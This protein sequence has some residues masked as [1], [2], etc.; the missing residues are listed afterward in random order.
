MPERSEDPT[1]ETREERPSGRDPEWVA[2]VAALQTAAN[3][4]GAIDVE[5]LQDLDEEELAGLE[6]ELRASA[7]FFEE[8]FAARGEGKPTVPPTSSLSTFSPVRLKKVP[9]TLAAGLSSDLSG[10][11]RDVEQLSSFHALG[12]Y[13]KAVDS[14]RFLSWARRKLTGLPDQAGPRPA[15]GAMPVF[16]PPARPAPA[17]AKP[18]PPG[19]PALQRPP[20]AEPRPAQ[21]RTSSSASMLAA[22]A[23]PPEAR[24]TPPPAAVP[25]Q[26]TAREPARA[27]IDLSVYEIRPDEAGGRVTAGPVTVWYASY[28]ATPSALRPANQAATLAQPVKGGVAFALAEGLSSSLGARTAAA[29][30]VRSFC[31]LAMAAVAAG[32]D[33]AR[34]VRDG[35]GGTHQRLDLLSHALVASGAGSAALTLIRGS[36]PADNALKILAHTLA[37]DGRLKHVGPALT[38][39]FTGGVL[40]PNP[41]TGAPE[42]WL[43]RVGGGRA[44]WRRM[45]AGQPLI[46]PGPT[47][48][49]PAVLGPGPTG[50]AGLAALEVKG[51]YEV[52]LGDIVV[53][54]GEE[55]MR[56]GER[57]AW[58]RLQE[59][60]PRFET[61]GG[62]DDRARRLLERVAR[63]TH[64][65]LGA[66]KVAD[67]DLA[68]VLLSFDATPAA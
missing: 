14:V 52:R 56:G 54:A 12:L 4:F 13:F 44:E 50:E 59:A 9:R 7:H 33:G 31:Q 17:A 30:A 62:G 11:T 43:G 35:I 22:A 28:K 55:L 60:E 8:L 53:L 68:L 67:E 39:T 18:A 15:S 38:V 25:A 61:R 47:P 3:L 19:P 51:P 46:G 48:P 2:A 34:A 63:R 29:I 1:R 65:S 36:L 21:P 6:K 58:E 26:E 16:V 32:G 20:V 27:G 5:R 40:A 64:A 42:L 10:V 57:T 37:P 23:L 49:H 41:V 24:L 66:G 45:G